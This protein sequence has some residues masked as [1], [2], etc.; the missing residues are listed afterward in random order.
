MS[1]LQ[2]GM[3][4]VVALVPPMNAS[5]RPT[6]PRTSAKAAF[7]AAGSAQSRP[8]RP[9]GWKRCRFLECFA[10]G[11]RILHS[12]ATCRVGP[13]RGYRHRPSERRDSAL[14]GPEPRPCRS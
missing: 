4:S 5:T 12:K 13:R 14:D 6:K 3:G 8:A 11:E 7:R 9:S 10:A 1:H 2:A